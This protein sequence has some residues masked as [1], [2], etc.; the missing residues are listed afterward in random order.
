MIRVFSSFDQPFLLN[1][2]M[3]CVFLSTSVHSPGKRVK[4]VLR[5]YI[6]NF[7][8]NNIIAF[9]QQYYNFFL[10]ENV[11]ISIQFSKNDKHM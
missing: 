11:D 3:H 8:S 5:E 7:L 1:R 4:S 6:Y 10:T 2:Q 9:L